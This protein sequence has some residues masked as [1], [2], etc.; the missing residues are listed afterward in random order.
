MPM[1]N[2][3]E[4]RDSYSMT[5]GSFWNYYRD[6]VNA[7]ENENDDDDDDNNNN[8]N[9]R[10]KSNKTITSKFS[11]YKTKLIRSTPNHNNIFATEIIVPLKYLSNFWRSVDLPLI[12]CEKELD[13][14]WRKNCAISGVSRTIRA[15]GDPSVQELATQ[16]TNDKISNK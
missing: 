7:D 13:L 9:N 8:N 6:E 1:H 15:I 16:T 5:S 4:H 11:E 14:R 3:L 12:H 10:I 2:L